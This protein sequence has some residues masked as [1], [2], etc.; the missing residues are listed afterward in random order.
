VR[1]PIVPTII[2]LVNVHRIYFGAWAIS[3][4]LVTAG[5]VIE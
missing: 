5:L 2:E 3:A 4:V 1:L